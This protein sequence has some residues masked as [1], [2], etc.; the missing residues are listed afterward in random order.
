[1]PVGTS[2]T[3]SGAL[4]LAAGILQDGRVALE[5]AGRLFALDPRHD[6]VTPLGAVRL[7]A[8]PA[9]N[10]P[11][12]S[13]TAVAPH[14]THVAIFAASGELVIR[15]VRTGR[16]LRRVVPADGQLVPGEG[17]LPTTGVSWSPNDH[18]LV[19]ELGGPGGALKA[20]DEGTGREWM[21]LHVHLETLNSV[22]WW[23]DG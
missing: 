4:G 15:D 14:G 10:S 13:W 9:A 18:I 16:L 7:P 22:T 12:S 19:Y 20:V 2:A 23:P 1:L 11:P 8:L 17:L 5:R 3:S 6:T 21:L